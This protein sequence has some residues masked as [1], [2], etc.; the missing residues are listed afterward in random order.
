MAPLPPSPFITHSATPPSPAVAD[1]AGVSPSP[2]DAPAG[3]ISVSDGEVN[4]SLRVNPARAGESELSVM[5]ACSPSENLP[6]SSTGGPQE[7]PALDAPNTHEYAGAS[8]T[9]TEF[10]HE[11]FFYARKLMKGHRAS[12]CSGCENPEFAYETVDGGA[13]YRC[14]DCGK[15]V[16][17]SGADLAAASTIDEA[18]FEAS[19]DEVPL[20]LRE[21]GYLQRREA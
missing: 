18:A 20:F 17:F 16:H 6:T 19:I 12:R 10:I 21:D 8:K 1:T 5:L 14:A 13:M 2:P 3:T 9:G 11:I 4:S 15:S 7:A